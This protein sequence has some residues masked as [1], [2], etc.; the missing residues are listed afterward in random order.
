MLELVYF[1]CIISDLHVVDFDIIPV[2]TCIIIG[3]KKLI[4]TRIPLI[5]FSHSHDI[6]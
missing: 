4:E 5:C 2:K 6:T 3:S 1:N